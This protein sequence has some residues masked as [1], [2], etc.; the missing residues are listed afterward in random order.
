MNFHHRVSASNKR[1]QGNWM[2]VL[3]LTNDLTSFNIAAEICN[4]MSGVRNIDLLKQIISNLEKK[5]CKDMNE[6]KPQG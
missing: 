3:Q 1:I 6:R 4:L 5:V 2:I